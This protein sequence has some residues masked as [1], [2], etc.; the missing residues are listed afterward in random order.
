MLN[1][2]AFDRTNSRRE[3]E[4]L[5]L[6][7]AFRRKKPALLFPNERRIEALFDRRPDGERRS[8]VV[9]IDRKVGTIANAD[10]INR[11][12]QMI[13]RVPSKNVG[14]PR[15]DAHC[16]DCEQT[17]FAPGFVGGKLRG[18][19]RNS[20]LVV[21]ISGMRLTEVHRHIEIVRTGGETRVEDRFVEARVACVHDDVG[22]CLGD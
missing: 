6:A 16:D 9:A 14:Q 12:E 15:L 18:T 8:K 7:K 21:R 1:V 13:S 3:V 5:W 2:D 22:V 19:K 10:F 11:V 4:D 20:N 17:L